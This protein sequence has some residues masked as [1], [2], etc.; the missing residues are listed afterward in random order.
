LK[1]VIEK[2]VFEFLIS[3]KITFIDIIDGIAGEWPQ[4]ARK[5]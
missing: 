5:K 3:G 1:A 4:P 2:A